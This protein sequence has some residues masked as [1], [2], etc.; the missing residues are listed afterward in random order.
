MDTVVDGGSESKEESSVRQRQRNAS[1]AS[2]STPPRRI[3]TVTAGWLEL[4][5]ALRTVY[6]SVMAELKPLGVVGMATFDPMAG[7]VLWNEQREAERNKA[8]GLRELYPN[9]EDDSGRVNPTVHAPDVEALRAVRVAVKYAIGAYGT[10][11][12]VLS[13]ASFR[14]K[15]KSLKTH[16]A[17]SGATAKDYERMHALASEACAKSCEIDAGD[18]IDADW[19]GTEFSPSSFVAVDRA[20]GKVALSVRGTWELHDALTDVNSE[21]VEFLGGWAHAGMVASAWQVAKR[22]IP[23]VA[24]A[25]AKN[26]SFEFLVTGH[27]MGGGVAA[28]I[29]MLMH[30]TDSDIE[31]LALEGLGGEFDE[32]AKREVL[33]RL[34]ACKCVCIAAPSVSSMDLSDKA[35]DYITCVVAGAD[36]V[37]RLCHA[38]VRRLLRRLNHAAPSHAMLRAVSSVLG[39]RDRPSSKQDLTA[40]TTDEDDDED[41][42]KA[43]AETPSTSP[44][45]PT[46]EEFKPTS[47]ARKKKGSKRTCQGD[48]NDLEDVVGLELRDHSAMD[49][50]VQ[51][52]RVIHLKHVRSNAP[53]AEYKHPTAFTD[54]L[55]DPYMMLDHIPGTYQAAVKTIHDRVKAGGSAWIQHEELDR[56]SD[57][58]DEEDAV[59]ALLHDERVRARAR[60]G[61]RSVRNFLGIEDADDDEDDEDDED[62]YA[63]DNVTTR[64]HR[65]ERTSAASTALSNLDVRAVADTDED[66]DEIPN[67]YGEHRHALEHRHARPATTTT[68]TTTRPN[69]EADDRASGARTKNPLADAWSW[70]NS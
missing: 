6:T 64:A 7:F 10:A 24:A 69:I 9:G 2:T 16:A 30:S 4:E 17:A 47:S 51:P 43:A 60:R 14:E 15:L 61:W 67:Y 34:A 44:S 1:T 20:E 58:E 23:A 21:S 32:D 25:L 5:R 39:G 56:E 55:L 38:S 48:W 68:S 3:K 26:P 66:E 63:E 59:S 65:R 28:C 8:R 50:M 12:S 41:E 62:Q 70:L 53:T 40:V 22:M 27:S 49:F 29:A 46:A 13:D 31:K 45:K 11:S 35:S 36:V 18:V 52:G 54:V 57:E 33:T 42:D 19:N 37:P